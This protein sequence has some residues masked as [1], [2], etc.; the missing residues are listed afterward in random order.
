MK[1]K[2][3]PTRARRAI[4]GA[5]AL[6]LTTGAVAVPHIAGS[7]GPW[8]DTIA[9]KPAVLQRAAQPGDAAP[10]HWQE[11]SG[12]APVAAE[13]R[14]IF[15]STGRTAWLAPSTE[16]GVCVIVQVDEREPTVMAGCFLA[17]GLAKAAPF[18]VATTY[19]RTVGVVVADGLE[20][21][22]ADRRG[23]RVAGP[24]LV[25]LETTDSDTPLADTDLD[26]LRRRYP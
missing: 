15:E 6:T 17:D 12:L 14:R 20:Q 4:I 5:V 23:G 22:E 10:D 26:E 25:L 8:D 9:T 19:T 16:G 21:R 7:A 2:L 11:S 1:K 3:T 13:G 24:N 18:I